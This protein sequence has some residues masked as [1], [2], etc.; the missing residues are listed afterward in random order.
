LATGVSGWPLSVGAKGPREEQ[1]ANTAKLNANTQAR[2]LD[3]ANNKRKFMQ[4]P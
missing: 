4:K 3:A 1:P 2:A